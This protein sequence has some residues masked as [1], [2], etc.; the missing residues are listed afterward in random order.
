M[1][2]KINI[3]KNHHEDVQK[4]EPAQSNNKQQTN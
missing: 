3:E 2:N 1:A 4:K